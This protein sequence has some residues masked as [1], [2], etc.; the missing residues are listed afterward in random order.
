[1]ARVAVSMVKV[2]M[3]QRL[4]SYHGIRALDLARTEQSSEASFIL[5]FMVGHN[6][7]RTCAVVSKSSRFRSYEDSV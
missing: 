5:E 6:V 7:H 2:T 4:D 3:Y 1:V